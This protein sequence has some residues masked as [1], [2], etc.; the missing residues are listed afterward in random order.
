MFK[1]E[2]KALQD[3]VRRGWMYK[4]SGCWYSKKNYASRIAQLLAEQFCEAEEAEKTNFISHMMETH[5]DQ[6][7]QYAF[8]EVS[9]TWED[10]LMERVEFL[11]DYV[12]LELP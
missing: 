2:K 11:E 12:D 4:K 10:A 7:M 3:A 9:F 8:S 1:F 6:L 5:G